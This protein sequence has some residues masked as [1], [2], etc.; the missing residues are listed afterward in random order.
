MSERTLYAFLGGVAASGA[1]YKIEVL[2]VASGYQADAYSAGGATGW[3]KPTLVE[4]SG[5]LPVVLRKAL[6]KFAEKTRPGRDRTYDTPMYGG[7]PV[8][9]IPKELDGS[10][11]PE[12][13]LC[14]QMGRDLALLPA[15]LH[16]RAMLAA[17]QDP[18]PS[19]VSVAQI[20]TSP[21]AGARLALGQ[22]VMLCETIADEPTLRVLMQ[23]DGWLMTEKMEGDRGQL[24]HDLAGKVYLTNRSGEV[25]TCPPHIIQAMAS[26]SRG[27]SFDGE[28]ITVDSDGAAQLYVGARANIQLFVAF[29]LLEHPSY[30]SIQQQPQKQRLRELAALLPPFQVP[31]QQNGPAI[32]IVRWAETYDDKLDLLEE[33][34]R[35]TGEGWVLRNADSSYE[36]RRS[37]NWMRFR[38]R[39]KELDAVVLDYKRGTGKFANTVGGVKCGLYDGSGRIQSIGWVGSGWSDELRAEFWNR[40]QAGVNG[41]VIT[42]KSFG[43][44]FADQ[45]IRPSGVRIRT[46]GDK[47]PAECTFESEA[48]RP[49]GAMK[50]K[51]T[52]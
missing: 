35:R 45:V 20:I 41:Y 31:L 23:Q 1:K 11:L 32:R 3:T 25:V 8:G 44:S 28:V 7:S 47:R 5:L 33:V 34:R 52:V 15:E 14:W 17:G 9:A 29:D 51:S 27:T 30:T 37:Y 50:G 38:D 26:M 24:H 13:P 16:S 10:E 48:G 19:S 2:K 6:A 42:V 40:W 36:G 43:L 21:P 4:R 39:E 49:F 22:I 18:V 12:H 46:P